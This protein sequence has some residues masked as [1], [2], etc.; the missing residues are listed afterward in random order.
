[1]ASSQK[2]V[3]Q[4][5]TLSAPCC[6][7]SNS[8]RSSLSLLTTLRKYVRV[9]DA[10]DGVERIVY[11]EVFGAESTL[12][13]HVTTVRRWLIL[14]GYRY[15]RIKKRVYVDGHE[16]DDVREY[17]IWFLD[18]MATYER[19]VLSTFLISHCPYLIML[20]YRYMT[21]YTPDSN[22]ILQPHPP[23]LRPGEKEIIAPFHDESSF[24]GYDMPIMAGPRMVTCPSG[25]KVMV[26]SSWYQILFS[27]QP[28]PSY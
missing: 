22:G 6:L 28:A 16:R 1:M 25:R 19:Y 18:Q 13:V 10:K 4:A 3:V 26:V 9:T 17:R 11:P 7:M 5:T 23:A 14:V 12:T 15:S 2:P 21:W 24:H 8:V 27:N 20:S